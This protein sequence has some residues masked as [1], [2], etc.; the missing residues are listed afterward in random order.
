MNSEKYTLQL[1][2]EGRLTIP[3]S[4]RQR[5]GLEKGDRFILSLAEDNTIMLVSLR[6][7]VR[8][9]RGILKDKSPD[10]N[11]VDELIQERREEEASE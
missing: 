7:N 4:V 1:E 6:E 10:R 9:M 5:L 11:L 3:V 2:T 8:K